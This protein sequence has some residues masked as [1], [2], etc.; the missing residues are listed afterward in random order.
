[1]VSFSTEQIETRESNL[2]NAT[3]GTK[4]SCQER[5]SVKGAVIP[6]IEGWN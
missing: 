4:N 6:R 1:M 2:A 3:R 5:E